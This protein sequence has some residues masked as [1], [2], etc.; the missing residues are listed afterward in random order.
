MKLLKCSPLKALRQERGWS[1]EPVTSALLTTG[2]VG[3]I[4][5]VSLEPGTIRGN[6]VHAKQSEWVVTFGGECTAAALDAEGR[7][8]ERTFGP[9]EL[10]LIEIPPGVPHAFKNTGRE[11]GYLLALCSEPYVKRNPDRKEVRVL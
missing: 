2:G 7:R 4:H 10:V 6:H 8:E 9:D 11:T 5:L 3:N 1:I